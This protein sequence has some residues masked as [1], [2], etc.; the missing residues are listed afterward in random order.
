MAR[1][2][3]HDLP[4]ELVGAFLQ[5][6]TRRQPSP[7]LTGAEP[8]WLS[9]YHLYAAWVTWCTPRDI[10]YGSVRDFV[11]QLKAHGVFPGRTAPGNSLRGNQYRGLELI[12]Q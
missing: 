8:V 5:L 12:E 9:L 11:R 4:N 1:G 3:G 6:R 10:D 7:A 2:T